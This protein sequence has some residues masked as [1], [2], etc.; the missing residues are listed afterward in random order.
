MDLFNLI[1]IAHAGVIEDAPSFAE[2][3]LN[4]LN[5]LLRV[6]GILGIIALVVT[7]VLYFFAAGDERKT[8][9]AKKMT[10][11]IVVGIAVV[12]GSMIIVRQIIKFLV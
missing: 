4:V 9:A 10:V 1:N 3:F 6:S 8:D 7:G 2:V 5:F 12:L 11:Y